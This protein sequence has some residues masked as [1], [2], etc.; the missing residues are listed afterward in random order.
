MNR[1]AFTLIELLVVVAIIGILAAVG[2]VAYNGYTSAAKKK[3]TEAKHKI[4][5]NFIQN[6]L[7]KCN[8]GIENVMIRSTGGTK[9]GKLVCANRKGGGMTTN[10]VSWFF[11]NYRN[12]YDGKHSMDVLL[13]KNFHQFNP[14]LT[15]KTLATEKRYRYSVRKELNF[16]ARE[17]TVLEKLYM[18]FSRFFLS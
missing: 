8:L 9:G 7:G 11:G 13:R 16:S 17:Q 10:A 14:Y 12:P 3:A 1:K 2:V 6:E 5:V 15:T 18:K 4:V